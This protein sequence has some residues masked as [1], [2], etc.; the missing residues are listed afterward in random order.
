MG[1]FSLIFQKIT[2]KHYVS[3]QQKNTGYKTGAIFLLWP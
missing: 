1:L 2:S 3:K